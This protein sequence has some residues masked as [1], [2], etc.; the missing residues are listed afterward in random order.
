LT[1]KT[2]PRSPAATC[3]GQSDLTIRIHNSILAQMK[4]ITLQQ[5]MLQEKNRLRSSIRK[6]C[7]E[8][9]RHCICARAIAASILN[10]YAIT[11]PMHEGASR[12]CCLCPWPQIGRSRAACKLHIATA[13]I[14]PTSPK[15]QRGDSN[16]CGQSPMDFESISLTARTHCHA[17]LRI[18]RVV[19]QERLTAFNQ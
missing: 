5:N 12:A 7:A 11:N 13:R 15:R 2:F 17:L 1:H 18:A 4:R 8:I 10:V 16:P 14:A 6:F 9:W 3:F 19:A